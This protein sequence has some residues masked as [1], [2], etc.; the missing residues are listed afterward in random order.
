MDIDELRCAILK[1]VIATGTEA[2]NQVVCITSLAERQATVDDE[3][4]Q[5]HDWGDAM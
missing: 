3:I 2:W 1:K 5:T 4:P